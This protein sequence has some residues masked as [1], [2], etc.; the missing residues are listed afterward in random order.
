MVSI[1]MKRKCS[2]YH[3]CRTEGELITPIRTSYI[4]SLLKRINVHNT[5]ILILVD[6]LTITII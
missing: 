3:T 2:F 6:L 1:E 4:P 5:W